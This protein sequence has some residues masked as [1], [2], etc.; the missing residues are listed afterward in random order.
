MRSREAAFELD[1]S[2][3]I[4]WRD[5]ATPAHGPAGRFRYLLIKVHLGYDL[6]GPFT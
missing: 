1:G 2:Y 4:N 6:L 3:R 5:F